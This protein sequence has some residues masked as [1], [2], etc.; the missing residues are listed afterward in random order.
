MNFLVSSSCMAAIAYLISVTTEIMI[1][2]IS[3]EPTTLMTEMCKQI[4][5]NVHL[6]TVYSRLHGQDLQVT[7]YDN[8]NK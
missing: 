3:T 7:A 5:Y 1:Q 2:I 6:K 4:L 8:T